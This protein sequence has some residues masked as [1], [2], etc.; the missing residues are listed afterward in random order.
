MRHYPPNRYKPR[1]TIDLQAADELHALGSAF[2]DLAQYWLSSAV[3]TRG[4][5]RHAIETAATIHV[6]ADMIHDLAIERQQN[7]PQYPPG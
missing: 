4:V 5:T 3:V 2:A 6:L 1:A 7:P